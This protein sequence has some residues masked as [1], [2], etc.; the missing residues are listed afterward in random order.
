MAVLSHW[1]CPPSAYRALCHDASSL[2]VTEPPPSH[3]SAAT[4]RRPDFIDAMLIVG[5]GL[6]SARGV[7][8]WAARMRADQTAPRRL[9]A[10]WAAS[11]VPLMR[12]SAPSAP[13]IPLMGEHLASDPDTGVRSA[14]A[15]S[16]SAAD[17]LVVRMTSGQDPAV[18]R[19][20]AG[21]VAHSRVLE[22]LAADPSLLV[23]AVVAANPATPSAA[24][25]RLCGD[26][27]ESVAR[28]AIRNPST[29]IAAARRASARRSG[30]GAG[31][32][33]SAIERLVLLTRWARH[34]LRRLRR[35][36]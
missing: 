10:T 28:A 24:L 3:Y 11:D 20:A 25:E 33:L 26:P 13:T 2:V 14:V 12:S 8:G 4:L 22:R 5:S 15:R 30:G 16:R 19:A 7:S 27:S 29:L 23:R 1:A 36:D 31:M 17:H 32:T 21:A 9:V 18:R 6:A 34:G 35:D